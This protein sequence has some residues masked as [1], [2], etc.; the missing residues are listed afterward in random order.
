[1]ESVEDV[2]FGP[3][4]LKQHDERL[5]RGEETI[6]LRPK[7]LAVLRYLLERPGRAVDKED[8]LQAVWPDGTVAGRYRF[9]H[10][11]Y[12]EV[13]YD[14]MSARRRIQLHH[15]IGEREETGYREQA[16]EHAAA[17]AVHFERGRDYAR[18]L[19]YLQQAAENALRRAAWQEAI[20]HLTTALALLKTLSDTG[21]AGAAGIGLTDRPGP[22]LDRH[23]GLCRSRGATRLQPR[24][25]TLS[26]GGRRAAALSGAVGAVCLLLWTG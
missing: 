5:W 26:A 21:R 20:R 19:Q 12:Q 9:R 11:L 17:L 4:Q 25:G 8:L 6:V 14:R 1:M 10:A 2:Q 23:Q 7:S 13:L 24:P 16:W 15:R 22:S 3:F 18:A